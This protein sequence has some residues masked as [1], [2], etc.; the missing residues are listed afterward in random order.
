MFESS[1][2]GNQIMSGTVSIPLDASV[3]ITRM[4]VVIEGDADNT[5]ALPCGAFTWGEVE[6]YSVNIKSILL[7]CNL[8]CYWWRKL[9][10][11][12]VLELK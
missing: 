2:T 4:R 3:G 12:G 11:G 1:Y 9:L 8:Q 7:N 10:R 5:G 6:D